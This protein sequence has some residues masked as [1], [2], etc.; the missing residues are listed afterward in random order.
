[1]LFVFA[2]SG[3]ENL[4]ELNNSLTNVADIVTIKK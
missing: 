2:I 3:R 4:D 1:V